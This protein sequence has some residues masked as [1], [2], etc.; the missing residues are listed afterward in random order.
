MA[1]NWLKYYQGY[2]LEEKHILLKT[3]EKNIRQKW[4]LKK[5][6][7]IDTASFTYYHDKAH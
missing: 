5:Q 1:Y 2:N 6:L 7:L 4:R 3:E